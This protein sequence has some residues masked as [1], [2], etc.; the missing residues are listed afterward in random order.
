[1]VAVTAQI[2]YSTLKSLRYRGDK[3]ETLML[4]AEN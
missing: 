2:W 3:R 4:I 1:M